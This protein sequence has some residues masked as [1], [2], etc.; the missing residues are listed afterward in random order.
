MHTHYSGESCPLACE[1]TTNYVTFNDT[2]PPLPWNVNACRSHFRIASL[3]LCFDE[4]CKQDGTISAWIQ[5]H[6]HSCLADANVTL[7]SFQHV[8][9]QWQPDDRDRVQRLSAVQALTFP[10]V[11][12]TVLPEDALLER[13]FTTVVQR[14]PI[15]TKKG[16]IDAN[17]FGA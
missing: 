5:N 11:N 14:R 9:D 6:N 1:T 4:F 7:P 2:D 17:K 3:Y 10:S 15:S 8:L 13:A 16:P 12:H